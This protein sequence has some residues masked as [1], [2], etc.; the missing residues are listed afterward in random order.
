MP[1][2]NS[3]SCPPH[4]GKQGS[5]S[6]EK[7]PAHPAGNAAA[8]PVAPEMPPSEPI[9]VAR[10]PIFTADRDIWGYE[11]LFRHSGTAAGAQVEDQ[12]VA[13]A[14]VIADGYQL[15]QS[16]IAADKRMLINFP[17]N[18]IL[19]GAAFTLPVHQCVPEILEHVE[20]TP[21]ILE[22]C[23]KLKTAGYTLALDDYV[24]QPGYEELMA[25][26]DIVKV[27]VLGMNAMKLKLVT[28]RLRQRPV[29]L[30]AEK[31]E[32]AEMF[33]ACR[34]LGYSLFQGYHFSRPEI[35]PG[36]KVSSAQL[37]KARL[38]AMLCRDFD[39][40]ELSHV[41]SRD[42]SL[43]FRL[44][45]YINSAA[46]GLRKQVESVSQAITLLGQNP[47]RQWLMVVLVADMNPS[48][49]AQEITF[50]SVL[51][52]RFLEQ[53]ARVA[54]LPAS[55]DTMFLVGLLSRIDV[56]MGMP[57]AELMEQIPLEPDIRDA[58]LGAPNPLRQWLACVEALEEGRF[59]EARRVLAIYGISPKDAA[60]ARLTATEWAQ[61]ILGQRD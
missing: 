45:K 48:H 25:L 19:S 33:E 38:L 42:A 9:F 41:V 53:T 57:M 4:C 43:T 56:L 37:V 39:V 5:G 32:T 59:D 49:A 22:A 44:L 30:L 34:D 3:R 13:T 12:D 27:E 17:R 23:A 46:F 11:L 60:A 61:R 21:D 18:L 8:R 52:G 15:A 29:L 54:R 47:I 40:D 7:A 24:G 14:R 1:T 6:P 50:L 58:F 51:R 10:Q 2:A 31:V 36:S 35:V 26:T 28:A 20:P 55:A 16:Q